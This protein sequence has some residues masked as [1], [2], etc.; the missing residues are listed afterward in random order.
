MPVVN[1]GTPTHI[2][3]PHWAVGYNARREQWDR[4]SMESA[5]E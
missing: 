3:D 4:E 5:H 2:Q 1:E